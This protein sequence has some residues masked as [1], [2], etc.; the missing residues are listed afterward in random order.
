MT[1]PDYNYNIL[2]LEEHLQSK[3]TRKIYISLKEQQYLALSNLLFKLDSYYIEQKK[4][5]HNKQIKE[6]Q[7]QLNRLQKHLFLQYLHKDTEKYILN[8]K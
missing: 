6:E 1:K 4:E 2:T 3:T 8:R 7:K 5:C